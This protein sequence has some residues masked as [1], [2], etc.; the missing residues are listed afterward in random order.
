MAKSDLAHLKNPQSEKHQ[1]L[2][3]LDNIFGCQKGRESEQYGDRELQVTDTRSEDFALNIAISALT[4]MGLKDFFFNNDNLENFDPNRIHRAASIRN[5]FE[6]IESSTGDPDPGMS[7][8]G[9]ADMG[10]FLPHLSSSATPDTL[11]NFYDNV[12]RMEID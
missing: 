12:D 3:I 8:E 6:A 11:D 5:P 1:G 9:I 7:D 4:D 2:K 10:S